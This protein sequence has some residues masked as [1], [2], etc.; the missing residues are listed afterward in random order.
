MP[1]PSAPAT[2]DAVH[3]IRL[4]KSEDKIHPRSVDGFYARWRWVIVALT[5]AVPIG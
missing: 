2:G 4:Y 5:Q 1:A 3:V